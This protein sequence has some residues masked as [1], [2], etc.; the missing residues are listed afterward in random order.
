[1]ASRLVQPLVPKASSELLKPRVNT[2]RTAAKAAAKAKAKAEADRK[3]REAERVHG[4]ATDEDLRRYSEEREAREEA[5]P[6]GEEDLESHQAGS[7]TPIT[8]FGRQSMSPFGL[9]DMLGNVFEWTSTYYEEGQKGEDLSILKGGSW[10][11]AQLS[12]ADRLIEPASTWSNTISF[13]CAVD[14][15]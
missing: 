15:Y 2:R 1:M 13:R 10:A 8:F 7:T 12:C 4:L 5:T 3:A 6:A 9:L 14:A 11:S